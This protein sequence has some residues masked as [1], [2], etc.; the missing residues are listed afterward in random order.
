MDFLSLVRCR[1]FAYPASLRL[2]PRSIVRK[3]RL[4]PPPRGE[5]KIE[6]G[7]GYRPRDG[8]VHVDVARFPHVEVL[9]NGVSLPFKNEWGEEILAIHMLEHVRPPQ[10]K[11]VLAEWHRVLV[12]GGRLEIHVPNGA[13]L[14]DALQERADSDTIWAIEGAVFGY[15]SGPTERSPDAL[16]GAPDH[17]IL[18]TY[19]LLAVVLRDAGFEDVCDIS[20]ARGCHHAEFWRDELPALCLE[21]VATRP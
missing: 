1:T 20:S 16:G 13:V 14:A 17:R 15:G 7:S 8:Y 19:P 11:L 5:R 2:V 4:A 9:S 18:W 6:I 3:F 21:V 12:S 10:I